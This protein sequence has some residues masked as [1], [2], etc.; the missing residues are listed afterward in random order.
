MFNKPTPGSNFKPWVRVSPIQHLAV[1]GVFCKLFNEDFEGML[2]G[3]G[4][5]SGLTLG[6]G[7]QASCFR[8]VPIDWEEVMMLWPVIGRSGSAEPSGR[9]ASEHGLLGKKV[10]GRVLRDPHLM[11]VTE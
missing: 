9:T 3:D 4:W 1:A 8:P 5:M 7:S 11:R 10:Q 6:L 2:E